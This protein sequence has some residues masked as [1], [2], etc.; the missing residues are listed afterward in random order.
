MSV[1]HR[2]LPALLVLLCLVMAPW[3]TS[4]DFN[5]SPTYLE[6]EE[7]RRHSTSA[8]P[9]G[10][11][12]GVIAGTEVIDPMSVCAHPSGD[13][14]VSGGFVGGV[15]VGGLSDNT[16]SGIFF[17]RVDRNGTANWISVG[18]GGGLG[19][20]ISL[21]MHCA[22]D[23]TIYF[24]GSF[25]NQ[26][27]VNGIPYFS[28]GGDDAI[29]GRLHAN[30]SF[31][32]TDTISTSGNDEVTSVKWDQVNQE[33]VWV[34]GLG[35][36][37]ITKY[38]FTLTA[39]T[40]QVPILFT[41]DENGTWLNADQ[42]ISTFGE[43]GFYDV[44]V[45]PNGELTACGLFAQGTVSF[46][47]NTDTAQ[48]LMLL[49]ARYNRTTGWQWLASGETSAAIGCSADGY[50]V[51][52]SGVYLISIQ[53][54]QHNAN[55][56]GNQ[57]IFIARVNGNGHWANL[58]TAGG[59]GEDVAYRIG[60]TAGG[61]LLI[62]GSYENTV[63]FGNMTTAA[64]IGDNDAYVAMLNGTSY[65]WEWVT[66][67]S[68]D[69]EDTFFGVN[70]DRGRTLVI[71]RSSS[72]GL[73]MG[74]WG[75]SNPNSDY[76]MMFGELGHDTDGDGLMDSSDSCPNGITGWTTGPFSDHDGDGCRD[77]DE[78]LDDDDDGVADIDDNCATGLVS[79][80]PTNATDYDSD[81]CRDYDED[82]D[83][84]GD[85]VPDL[86]D[87]CHY[88]PKGW[89]STTSE[90]LDGDGCRDLDEDDDD[91][92]DSIL[93][94]SDACA[95][96][97]T[98]WL[99]ASSTDHDSDGCRDEGEDLDDDDDLVLDDAPDRCPRGEI[100]WTSTPLTDLDGDG[101]RDDGEDGDD[102]DDSIDDGSDGCYRGFTGW[103]S[104]NTNDLDGDGC[105]DDDEDGDDDGDGVDDPADDCPR[106]AT[107]W[108]TGAT[109]D[110]DGDG[111]QDSGED[112]DD[113]NDEVLDSADSC[114]IGVQTSE[115][116]WDYD[117]DGCHD[118][119]E[120]D[121]DD[122]DG[123]FDYLD[124]C[125]RGDM[126][127]TMTDHDD[128]GCRDETE[129]WDDDG[130]G[131]LD[132][133][134]SCPT[135]EVEWPDS[136][137]IDNDGDGCEDSIEDLDDDNDGFADD[138]DD[139]P[140]SNGNSTDDRDGCP[141]SDGDGWSD[142]DRFTTPHPIGFADAFRDDPTEWWDNDG[143]HVGDNSD[144]FPFDPTEW[145]DDDNDN[146]GDNTDEFPDDPNEW[147]DGDK[148]RVGDNGDACPDSPLGES[149]DV[150]GCTSTQAR[151]V[152]MSRPVVW[153]PA[154]LLFVGL[155]LGA[156]FL[157][158]RDRPEEDDDGEGAVVSVVE[159]Y[160][161]EQAEPEE[162]EHDVFE[163]YHDPGV[164]KE[165]DQQHS[166]YLQPTTDDHSPEVATESPSEPAPPTATSEA[167]ASSFESIQSPAEEPSPYV[168][169]SQPPEEELDA[170]DTYYQFALTQGYSPE[171]AAEWTRY[172]YPDWQG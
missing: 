148:D 32:W 37:Y 4:L 21:Q 23:G 85:G 35:M 159:T 120:D 75:H 110:H 16:T 116:D 45:M 64:A 15:S 43:G 132:E 137:G 131:V 152:S 24:A 65:T 19:E 155:L 70:V 63:T 163:P 135:G 91:D 33:V 108:L 167:L 126:G 73:S 84:D 36:G 130:D 44:V 55:S 66:V 71:G 58:A 54:G 104:N 76:F 30:G 96:G 123:V 17:A 2:P 69:G 93:D 106:G 144:P 41:T 168:Q 103:S 99:S 164:T 171:E 62:G 1:Q 117:G 114:P 156:I 158:L 160:L 128:D 86:T 166:P 146:V 149:V 51:D 68:G 81:G 157:Q 169:P 22:D 8:P 122:G 34:G 46:D 13:T 53:L 50:S 82:T 89:N 145:A 5:A 112:L 140:T 31:A 143:D 88:S 28:A 59:S 3:L 150:N 80:G 7:E 42:G 102:D 161:A 139:C 72:S 170:A 138:E 12:F 26:L 61:D 109:S 74:P 100:G 119:V 67:V 9:W 124:N 113:D 172:N 134:D 129:D 98:G 136:F 90:D 141:D 49:V 133:A 92:G 18:D 151:V 39:S 101:C 25:N 20:G 6:T 27:T 121:D 115:P 95:T 87:L 14:I 153:V 77:S 162:E 111:C 94:T 142:S 125:P 48:N 11:A 52:V 47:G 79:W 154:L 57:D 40:T 78:D 29:Y 56:V 165:L 60:R 97:E 107:G 105:R 10:F 118:D 147:L 127:W 83:D 38:G